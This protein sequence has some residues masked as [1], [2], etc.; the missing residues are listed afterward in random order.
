MV[1]LYRDTNIVKAAI[2]SVLENPFFN[3]RKIDQYEVK[4]KKKTTNANKN[5]KLT[6]FLDKH[7]GLWHWSE[8]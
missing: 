5:N 3:R 1:I 6:F 4:K 8:E 2:A 7:E